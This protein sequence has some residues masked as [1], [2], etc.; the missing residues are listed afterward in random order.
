[1]AVNINNSQENWFRMEGYI[2]EFTMQNSGCVMHN[3]NLSGMV[4]DSGIPNPTPGKL[5]PNF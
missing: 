4:H 1:M 5:I 2:V 3:N